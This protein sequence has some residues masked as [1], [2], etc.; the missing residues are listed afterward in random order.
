M[1]NTR[2]M[3]VAAA[4]LLLCI[5]I[6]GCTSLLSPLRANR[7]DLP[8]SLE[9]NLNEPLYSQMGAQ[10][11]IILRSVQSSPYYESISD[12]IVR[13]LPPSVSRPKG[14]ECVVVYSLRPDEA[15]GFQRGALRAYPYVVFVADSITKELLE[16]S[17]VTP[18][19]DSGM[20]LVE[21]LSLGETY[22][23]SMSPC[24][25]AE[26][27]RLSDTAA[28]AWRGEPRLSPKYECDESLTEPETVC[29]C[30]ETEPGHYDLDCL[31]VCTTGCGVLPP[32][33]AVT[34]IGGCYV[35]CWVPEYCIE[36]ECQTI[37]PC[38]W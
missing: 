33:Q 30:A 6:G 13:D 16:V 20:L 15:S 11:R 14:Q 5:L 26:I 3:I 23:C 18:D 10:E 38:P 7:V 4:I 1:K 2:W 22:T 28:K 34:C 29:W 24:V 19:V 17:K 37:Y 31:D 12:S 32:A 21:S 9:V 27:S 36:V 35:V 8:E 25:L